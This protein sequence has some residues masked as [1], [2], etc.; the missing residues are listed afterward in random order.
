MPTGK[1][2]LLVIGRSLGILR[3][4]WTKQFPQRR[5]HLSRRNKGTWENKHMPP[6]LLKKER[7]KK[8]PLIIEIV[9]K[10]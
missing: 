6:V 3:A 5:E 7:K 4:M 8:K 10:Y 9:L 2:K 1:E